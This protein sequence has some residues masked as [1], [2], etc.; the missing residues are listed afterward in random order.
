VT[1]K[2]KLVDGT[3]VYIETSDGQVIT[4][5]TSGSTTVQ[6]AQPGSLSDLKVGASVTVEGQRSGDNLTATKVTKSG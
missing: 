4:V 5:K 3:T 2:V 6:N 1:G